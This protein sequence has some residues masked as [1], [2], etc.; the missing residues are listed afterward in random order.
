MILVV[1][2]DDV[3]RNGKPEVMTMPQ[4]GGLVLLEEAEVSD[5]DGRLNPNFVECLVN[6]IMESVPGGVGV[7]E[8]KYF[9]A[10]SLNRPKKWLQPWLFIAKKRKCIAWI[11]CGRH[12]PGDF[13]YVVA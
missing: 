1:S 6:A 2:V 8:H 9:H 10:F 3:E 7:P 4:G 12:I 13:P 5:L 11:V